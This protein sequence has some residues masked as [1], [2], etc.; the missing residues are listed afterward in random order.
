ML[1]LLTDENFDE[2]IL[3]GL[4]RRLTLPD[5]LSVRDAGLAGRPDSF[6]L[7]WAVQQNRTILTHDKKTLTRDVEALVAKGEPM[8]GVIFVPQSLAIGRAISDLELVVT[9]YSQADMHDRIERLPL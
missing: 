3:R 2:D 8:A 5:L 6:L 7:S 4:R 9:C 1:R